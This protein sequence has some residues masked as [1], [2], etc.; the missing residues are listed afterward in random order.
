MLKMFLR[1][2]INFSNIC[3]RLIFMNQ[4]KV[5]IRKFWYIFTVCTLL[6]EI[7]VNN[8]TGFHCVLYNK[9]FYCK[10]RIFGEQGQILCKNLKLN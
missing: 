1:E 4:N 2:G 7:S 3:N 10:L 8:N 6:G 9:L 5:E